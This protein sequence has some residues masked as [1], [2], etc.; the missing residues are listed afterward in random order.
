MGISGCHP[1]H[2]R[3]RSFSATLAII[4]LRRSQGLHPCQSLTVTPRHPVSRCSFHIRGVSLQF[5]QVAERV[6]AI[7]F[8]GV[9]QAHEQIAHHGSVRCLVEHRVL[10]I[11]DGLLQGTFAQVMPT[12]GLCRVG[13]A[14]HRPLRWISDFRGSV[15]RHNHR[16]SRKASKGSGGRNRSGASPDEVAC[17]SARS[18]NCMSACR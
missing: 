2:G 8:A 9:N 5:G 17:A 13:L 4:I 12:A 6:H 3:S 1:N 14:E 18:F 10:A 15:G 16:L 7:Q 11:Q